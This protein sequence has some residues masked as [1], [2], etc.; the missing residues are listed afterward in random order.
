[1]A[2]GSDKTREWVFGT[3]DPKW[4]RNKVME[5]FNGKAFSMMV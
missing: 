2:R 3:P 5:I 1:V 4:D